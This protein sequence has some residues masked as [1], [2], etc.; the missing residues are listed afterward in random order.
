MPVVERDRE[1]AANTPLTEHAFALLFD[2]LSDGTVVHDA[3]VP[4]APV[5]FANRA[6]G[7]L[8]GYELDEIRGKPAAFLVGTTAD[9]KRSDAVLEALA[10]PEPAH[11]CVRVQR[12]DRTAF[13][14]EIQVRPMPAPWQ[15]L[16]LSVHRDVTATVLARALQDRTSDRDL[17]QPD[18]HGEHLGVTLPAFGRR[19][20]GTDVGLLVVDA[21]GR[22]TL[23]NEAAGD[24]FDRDDRLVT[25]SVFELLDCDWLADVFLPTAPSI[26]ERCA[27]R[28]IRGKAVDEWPVEVSV[29][30]VSSTMAAERLFV[31]LIVG[32]AVG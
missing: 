1:T 20:R 7:Q 9:D 10:S 21:R 25:H 29:Y 12:K 23:A 18:W 14:D 19:L 31:V 4:E 2:G 30:R 15:G 16:A 22:V 17:D 6:F 26:A 11:V 8:T 27:A 32:S 5:V 3:R 24:L 13:L 28:A